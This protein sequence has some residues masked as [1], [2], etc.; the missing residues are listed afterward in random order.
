[1]TK[2]TKQ[3]I[4]VYTSNELIDRIDVLAQ[5][6]SKPRNKIINELLGF[7]VERAE[8]LIEVDRKIEEQYNNVVQ[9]GMEHEGLW[10]KKWSL[11]HGSYPKR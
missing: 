2:K 3:T 9:T 1:M 7:A 11:E 5:I 8:E 10:T 4:G 6:N